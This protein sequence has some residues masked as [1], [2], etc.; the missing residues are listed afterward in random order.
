MFFCLSCNGASSSTQADEPNQTDS[1]K[2]P[3]WNH[4]RSDERLDDRKKM[5]QTLRDRYEFSNEEVLNAMLN[6]PR[7]WFVPKINQL[8]AYVDMPLPIGHGQT[9]SQPFI[10]AYMTGL[11]DLTPQMK[12]LEIGTG[13]GY[14]AAVL[15][16]FT[17]NVY[18]IEILAPL[19]KR[20]REQLSQYGYNTIKTK[21]G[22]G[23]KGWPQY[24]PFDAI[25]VTCAPDHI[26]QPLIE[27][28]KP[29]GKI[30]IPV[31]KEGY[32]QDLLLVTKKTDGS[33]EKKSMMPVRFV[34]L[35]RGKTED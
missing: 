32:V 14:Q 34:P 22:D 31:G 24:A 9:I 29:N 13:S 12:V 20:A 26:P 8:A 35:L 3:V 21:L 23:Y 7:H 30:V 6:V 28:L 17:P 19:A 11:L 4:P 27:Q 33:L 25:I 5:V 1:N 18:T 2:P 15:S 10:V 16:E